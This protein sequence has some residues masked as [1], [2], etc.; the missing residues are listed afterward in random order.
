MSKILLIED[1]QDL[2]AKIKDELTAER[3][4]VEVSHDGAEACDLLRTFDYDLII[5]DWML[6]G[7]SG[8]EIIR[9]LRDRKKATP[10]LMLTGK[11]SIENKE[12]GMDTGADD[13]LTKP[14]QMRELSLR[15]RTL[16]RRASGGVSNMLSVGDLTMDPVKYTL[17]R[18]GTEIRLSPVDFAL[19]EFLMR[20]PGQVFSAQTLLSRVW[21]YDSDAS[22]E[23]L[24]A[25]VRRI[26]KAVDTVDDPT[27]SII[28]N[29]SRV[30]YRLRMQ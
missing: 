15:V 27:Q 18:S 14:F 10:V 11:S 17:T 16:L 4:T 8:V 13:Y 20:N 3:Y 24:R 12:E 30:G 26:R 22:A 7:K 19:M 6:P 21:H 2:A 29:V 25:A 23:G 9:E 1:D 28:E 5:S